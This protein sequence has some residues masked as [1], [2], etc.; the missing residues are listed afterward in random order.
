MRLGTKDRAVVYALDRLEPP[1]RAVDWSLAA[2]I[3]VLVGTG[4][5]SLVVGDPSGAWV[6]DVHAVAAFALVVLLAFKLRRVATRLRPN[7][8]T[9]VRFVSILLAL[10]ALGA[11]G[12]GLWWAFGGSVRVG[13]WGLLMVH[14]TLGVAVPVVL[15]WHLRHRYH[16]PAGATH[17]GRRTALQYAAVVGLSALAW[18]GQRAA[19]DLLDTAGSDRR[20]TGSREEGSGEGNAFPVTSWVADD[21]TP[22]DVEDWELRVDGLVDDPATLGVDDLGLGDETADDERGDLATDAERRAVL[23]CTSGWY[24]DHDWRG[25]AVGDLLDAVEPTDD[26]RWVQFRSVTGYRWSLPVEEAREA[27]LATHVDGERISHDHGFPMRLVAPGRRG[28]Q[29][30]K[31]VTDVRATRRRDFSESV[32][33]FVSGFEE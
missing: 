8:L 26:A 10:T 27:L 16:S 23:D 3:A 28:F 22:V 32:A 7:R 29:W 21:P 24:S 1:P 13:P 11:L 19:N 20:F 17:Q 33:I 31:W 18:R 25:L 2:T 30:V 14:M 5:Y 9:R 4:L 12:T 6:F 15:L